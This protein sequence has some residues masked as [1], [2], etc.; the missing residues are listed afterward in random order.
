MFRGFPGG[1]FQGTNSGGTAEVL[2]ATSRGAAFGDVDNDGGMDVLVVNRDAP[3]Y[4]LHNVVAKQR[5]WIGF[6]VLNR[7]GA[8]A[9]EATVRL[10]TGGVSKRRDVKSAYSYQTANDPRIHVGLGDIG[11]VLDVRVR[12]ADGQLELFGDF[13]ADQVITLRRGSG[14]SRP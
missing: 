7:H 2:V 5:H 13:D 10:E 6:R 14:Q 12:W 11:Q 4:L 9:L 3:V 8:D 1:R